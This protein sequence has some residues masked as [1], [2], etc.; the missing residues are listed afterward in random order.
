M[1]VLF[2]SVLRPA[3]F[4]DCTNNGLSSFVSASNLFMDCSHEEAM[5]WCKEHG[6]KPETQFFLVP[7]KLWG[8]DH[9]YAEPLVKP[10]GKCQCFGGNFLYTSDSRM[11]RTGGTYK[12]PIPIHD[13][14]ETYEEFEAL[15]R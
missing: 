3:E 7:R 5:N 13:R 4:P 8:E 9:A 6:K 15:C 11:Y 10:D 12:L 2:V 1:T 14:F